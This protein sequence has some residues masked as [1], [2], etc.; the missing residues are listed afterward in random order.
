MVI[1][2]LKRHKSPGIDHIPAEVIEAGGRIIRSD[3][4]SLIISIWYY[5]RSGGGGSFYLFSRRLM[6]HDLVIMEAYHVCQLRTKL[7]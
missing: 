2:N 3:I 5:L 6:K 1:E 7:N 4:H